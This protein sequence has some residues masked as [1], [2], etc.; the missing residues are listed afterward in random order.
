MTVESFLF[1][2]SDCLWSPSKDCDRRLLWQENNNNETVKEVAMMQQLKE[3][4]SL[5]SNLSKTFAI[6]LFSVSLAACFEPPA[7]APVDTTDN[8]ADGVY[9]TQDNCTFGWLDPA[10]ETNPDQTDADMDGIGDICDNNDAD[11]DGI[12]DDVD[13]CINVINV[14]QAANIGN[15]TTLGDACDNEDG[16]NIVDL[17]DNCPLVANNDQTDSDGDTAGDACDNDDDNDGIDDGADSC[18]TTFPGPTDD[19][20]GDGCQDS[21]PDSDGVFTE[22]GDNCPD[23]SN[24]S[25]VDTDLDGQGDACDG[26]D[27]N[28]GID[29]GSDS[30]PL[31]GALTSDLDGNGCEDSDTDN[32]GIVDIA[33]DNCINVPNTSQE[34]DGPSAGAIQGATVGPANNGIGDACDSLSDVDADGVPDG[35]DNCP[36]TANGPLAGFNNQGDLDTDG[37]GDVCDTDRDGDGVTDDP[38]STGQGS[39]DDECPNDGPNTSDLDNNGCEDPDTDN[40]GT[41]D[42]IDNCPAISNP[43]QENALGGTSAGDACD[44]QDN[45]NVVDLNDNCL[46]TSNE[47][48]A[49]NYGTGLGDA[50]EDSDNDGYLDIDDNCPTEDST[51]NDDGTGC[52][53]TSNPG[54]YNR[55]LAHAYSVWFQEIGCYNTSNDGNP[56]ACVAPNGTGEFGFDC[57]NSGT[58][59]WNITGG[60]GGGN[61]DMTPNNCSFTIPDN[62]RTQRAYGGKYVGVTLVVTGTISGSSDTGGT[63]NPSG[64]LAVTGDYAGTVH[65]VRDVDSKAPTVP[66]TSAFFIGATCTDSACVSSQE[67]RFDAQS[68]KAESDGTPYEVVF[69]DTL[70]CA[71]AP[72]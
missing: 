61:S 3:L 48:Q 13:N 58:W 7:A 70:D 59:G 1:L 9:D 44:D 67:C 51:G 50:C 15:E 10:D 45:D 27:D 46:T 36:N 21:D 54:D 4:I 35:A 26:D 23:V 18:P 5:E 49:N 64:T 31:E 71:Y 34:D 28:D 52:I 25:Q 14:D 39:G 40:D 29:D 60:T 12:T 57:P 24:G 69:E 55:D 72:R 62:E 63:T 43:G 56:T 42:L 65:D 53:V 41:V 68:I 20:D 2:Q 22:A 8:D 17:S 33:P 30:C 66:G 19:N 38:T 47:N 37:I 16:D 11:S 32:D 6:T